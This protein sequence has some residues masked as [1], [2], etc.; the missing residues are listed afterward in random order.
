MANGDIDLVIDCTD[1]GNA[2]AFLEGGWSE[3]ELHGTWMVGAESALHLPLPSR[4]RAAQLRYRVAAF[5]GGGRLPRQRL[6]LWVNGARLHESEAL[7]DGWCEETVDLAPG[8]LVDT[9]RLEI[10]FEHPDAISPR[11]LALSTDPRPLAFLAAS[12]GV[13]G[14]SDGDRQVVRRQFDC[15]QGGDGQ[16][17][18]GEGW[19]PPESNGAWSVAPRCA[20]ALSLPPSCRDVVLEFCFLANVTDVICTV[21]PVRIMAGGV[22]IGRI[23][24]AA[25]WSRLRCEVPPAA[26]DGSG[27][28]ELVL[29]VPGCWAPAEYGISS[30][31]RPLGI[32]MNTLR[33]EYVPGGGAP[34]PGG[35]RVERLDGPVF[36]VTP[37]GNIANQMIQY[38]VALAFQARVPACRIANV[39]LP[40]WGI[41]LPAKTTSGAVA[42]AADIQHIALD[43]LAAR[44]HRGEIA[45]V[46]YCGFG[47][48]LEN[49]LPADFYREVFRGPTAGV[50]VCGARELLINVRG[51]EIIDPVNAGYTL[52]P[53]AFYEELIETTSLHPVFVGQLDPN[54]YTDRLRETFRG[55]TFTPSRGPA[56][57]FAMIRAARNV[58]VA[59]STFSW[60]AAWLSEAETIHLPVTGFY[61]LTQNDGV[62]LLP[63]D[64]PRYRFTLFPVNDSVS[65]NRLFAHHATMQGL[66]REVPADFLRGL[67]AGRPRFARRLDDY[68]AVFDEDA[69]VHLW[70]EV[71]AVCRLSGLSGPREHYR[72]LGF[73][74]NAAPFRLDREWYLHRYPLAA[75]EV[76]QGDFVD[77]HH[78]YAAI[79]RARG[80][81]PT[82]S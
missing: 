38:M 45:K 72:Q 30:D 65:R 51:A 62:D 54:L 15:R 70:P 53:L 5:T 9:D 1:R 40:M 46:D 22:E 71:P 19:A 82:A 42:Y 75:F 8:M 24:S 67:R 47:Q 34:M 32:C 28:L 52:V 31:P 23:D 44:M 50:P 63:L 12:V 33:C 16:M 17:V 41:H 49:F 2:L 4:L 27:R 18:F 20:M 77:L 73:A 36:E 80:Y 56:Q 57:D 35:A 59:V 21:Q 55:A 26:L 25:G 48:R 43:D 7:A 29:D 13:Q 39:D 76:G 61:N 81:W 69:Y 74:R 14:L 60:L 58:V 3:P 66:W 6:I 68:L 78:H 10:R 37:Q 64:D 11:S 79:G